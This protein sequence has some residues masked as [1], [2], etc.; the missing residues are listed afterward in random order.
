MFSGTEKKIIR[1]AAVA[2]FGWLSV[3]P[4]GAADATAAKVVGATASTVVVATVNPAA[5]E[6]NPRDT[7]I[8]KDGDRV[9][10][11][12][13][14]QEGNI[15]VFKA[16][17]FGELRVAAADAVVIMGEKSTGPVVV[18][19]VMAPGPKA[20][21]AK[22]EAA[23][24][25]AKAEERAEAEEISLWERFSPWR[26]TAQVRNFFG[27]WHGR[28]AASAEEV[29]N[30]SAQNSLALEGH[31]T[32]KWAHDEVQLNG[33]YDYSDTN[34]LTT[35][36]MLRADASWR[37]DFLES[38]RFVQYRPTVEWN[39]ANVRN[40]VPS[41]YV[42]LHQEIGG[43]Q[44]VFAKPGRVVRVGLSENLFD[45]WTEG[46][47]AS[48]NSHVVESGFVETELKLPWRITMKDRAVLYNPLTNARTGWENHLDLSKKLTET[49]SLSVQHEIRRNNP[50]GSAQDYKRLKLLLGL[51]F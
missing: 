16:D 14:G 28:F 13:L 37:H 24:A 15:I 5:P 40:G 47:V 27:P 38:G 43:G 19:P 3:A 29:S 1:G 8:Y 22:K 9:Q 45:T 7:L 4:A 18:A 49:L 17:R 21:V 30:N 39:R 25:Q 23:K 11:K 12:L 6:A 31:L 51:D 34:G 10:G 20:E 36:D 50:D 44:T 32:R 26:L 2:V 48:H 33:H 41:D 35:T 46:P 42:L